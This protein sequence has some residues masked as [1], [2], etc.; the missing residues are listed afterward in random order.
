[1]PQADG[2]IGGAPASTIRTL[3][4]CSRVR[5]PPDCL[6]SPRA[7]QPQRVPTMR[8][9]GSTSTFSLPS[10]NGWALTSDGRTVRATRASARWRI[11]SRSGPLTTFPSAK[12]APD[13]RQAGVASAKRGGAATSDDSGRTSLRNWHPVETTAQ[14]KSD[15]RP[16]CRNLNSMVFSPYDEHEAPRRY[17]WRIPYAVSFFTKGESTS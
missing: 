6:S 15:N 14:I 7:N 16:K 1:M 13:A 4:A 2:A 8:P 11:S 3:D 9:F 12:R 17:C 5:G 10:S